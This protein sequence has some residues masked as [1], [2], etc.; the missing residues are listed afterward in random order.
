M[1]KYKAYRNNHDSDRKSEKLPLAAKKSRK[2]NLPSLITPKPH[3]LLNVA[4][5]K[6]NS[7]T[8]MRGWIG[9]RD[10]MVDGSGARTK[11]HWL[12]TIYLLF[13]FFIQAAW[14]SLSTST[15]CNTYQTSYTHQPASTSYWMTSQITACSCSF[16]YVGQCFTWIPS[17]LSTCQSRQSSGY[18]FWQCLESQLFSSHSS[19]VCTTLVQR[20]LRRKLSWVTSCTHLSHNILKWGSL[21]LK[22]VW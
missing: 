17:S 3:L 6:I 1:A 11:T 5:L 7:S 16:L 8:S 22:F 21:T 2:R 12:E 20:T 10:T 13:V 14:L 15:V 19:K 9:R 4:L 18:C